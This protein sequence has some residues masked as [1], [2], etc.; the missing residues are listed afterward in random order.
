MVEPLPADEPMT[1]DVAP[2]SEAHETPET[3]ET[4]GLAPATAD[5]TALLDAGASRGADLPSSPVMLRETREPAETRG[6][7]R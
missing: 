1:P 5:E 4:P 6:Q 7:A 2:T 3:P